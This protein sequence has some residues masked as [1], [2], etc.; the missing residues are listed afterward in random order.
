[1]KIKKIIQPKI[2]STF[3]GLLKYAQK[4]HTLREIEHDFNSEKEHSIKSHILYKWTALLGQRDNISNFIRGKEM[5]TMKKA[6]MSFKE[7]L[8]RKQEYKL[9]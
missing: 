4:E 1:M 2:R 9:Q 3:D 7:H 8:I 5:Y 6:L